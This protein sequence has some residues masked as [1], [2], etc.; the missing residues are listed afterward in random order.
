LQLAK[1]LRDK[2]YL[3]PSD[4]LVR[5]MVVDEVN[6][7]VIVHNYHSRQNE[8]IEYVVAPRILEPVFKVSEVAKMLGRKPDTLRRYE[9][10]GKISRARQYSIGGKNAMRIYTQSDIEALA[11][12]FGEQVIGRPAKHA[13]VK[14]PISRQ[15][16]NRHYKTRFTRLT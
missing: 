14:T 2:Y 4:N 5:V 15:E 13:R 7:N 6:N 12:F 9:R 3:L 16:I 10:E 11:S 1:V 8:V